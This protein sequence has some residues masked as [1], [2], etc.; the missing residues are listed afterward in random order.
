[1]N[2][3]IE[4]GKRFW[5][6]YKR[7]RLA[8]SGLFF[9]LIEILTIALLPA[10]LHSDPIALSDDFNAAPGGAHLL[11]TDD[12]GR[13]LF[14]RLLFGGRASIFIGIFATLIGV[15]AGAAL[16]LLS[17]FYRGKTER[18]ILHAADVF[19][20]FPNMILILVMAAIFRPNVPALTFLIGVMFWPGAAR[21]IHGNV[22]TIRSREYVDS[23]RSIGLNDRTVALRYVLPNAIAPLWVTMP[24]DCARAILTESSLSFLGAGVQ[25]PRAS[26]G[27][28]IYSAQ[29]LTVLTAR[30]WEWIPAGL[31]LMCTVVSINFVGEGIRDALDTKI[32]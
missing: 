23:A 19:M 2:V 4:A 11:G 16:G 6:R 24:F 8:V 5:N 18:I 32:A 15:S 9:L 7:H 21:L 1:M 25:S 12:V 14:A 30:P 29:N 28:I 17:G 31:C 13:D 10:V 3:K 27:N 26:W 22:L 20:A